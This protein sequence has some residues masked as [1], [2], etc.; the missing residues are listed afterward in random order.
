MHT[1]TK[2]YS[3]LGPWTVDTPIRSVL[4]SF[5]QNS[6]QRLSIHICHALPVIL[7]LFWT[8]DRF[9][10]EDLDI[11]SFLCFILDTSQVARH[12]VSPDFIYPR[13]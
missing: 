11:I 8:C 5:Y 12:L 9:F 7:Y 2:K 4:A 13:L 6:L 1:Q 3:F 10:D